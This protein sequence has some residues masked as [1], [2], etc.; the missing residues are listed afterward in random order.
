MLRR[1]LLSTATAV[2]ASMLV[3]GSIFLLAPGSDDTA[4]APGAETPSSSQTASAFLFTGDGVDRDA[5]LR[6]ADDDAEADADQAEDS[7]DGSPAPE[8]PSEADEPSTPSTPDSGSAAPSGPTADFSDQ[9]AALALVNSA[10][11]DAGLPPM[12]I[13]SKLSSAAGAQAVHQASTQQMTHDGGGGLGA[14]VSAA[15]Y[16]WCAVAENVAAGYTSAS[17][18]HSGWMNSSGHR[19]NILSGNTEMGL[20]TATGGDGSVYWAQVFGTPC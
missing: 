16:T 9:N 11:A 8:T 15:G 2:G 5:I 6:A 18:V 19:A 1:V 14:R 3:V 4:T 12:T 17:A 7:D 10:R 20:A 13:N